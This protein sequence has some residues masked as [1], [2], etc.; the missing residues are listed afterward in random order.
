MEIV[1]CM[2]DVEKCIENLKKHYGEDGTLQ[3]SEDEKSFRL[4]LENRLENISFEMLKQ[5]LPSS[6]YEALCLVNPLTFSSSNCAKEEQL[7]RESF[8]NGGEVPDECKLKIS[9]I[10]SSKIETEVVKEEE[11]GGEGKRK[12]RK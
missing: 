8:H 5:F 1:D 9:S 12:K 2:N 3:L 11:G 7:L 4:E 6:T 10:Q